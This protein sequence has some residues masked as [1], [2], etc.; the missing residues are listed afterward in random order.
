LRGKICLSH[1]LPTNLLLFRG[2]SPCA[3]R[4][5]KGLNH[6][7]KVAC[8]PV[9]SCL[10]Y[11]AEVRHCSLSSMHGYR[12]RGRERRPSCLPLPV[13]VDHHLEIERR[14][15]YLDLYQRII[16]L[17]HR[18]FTLFSEWIISFFRMT[19][20][21]RPALLGGTWSLSVAQHP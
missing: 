21:T 7:N 18:P 20:P 3:G 8:A 13:P 14:S 9:L 1:F 12:S 10:F 2:K 11:F 4:V 5:V 6:M 16:P 19:H 15:I 17:N